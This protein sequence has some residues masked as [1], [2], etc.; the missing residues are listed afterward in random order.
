MAATPISG[1]PLTTKAS[2]GPE[3]MA[4]SIAAGRQRLLHAR[5]AAETDHLDV[6]AVLLEDAGLDADLQRHELERAGLRLADPHLGLR[7]RG[8]ASAV[9]PAGQQGRSVAS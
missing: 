9:R 4:M 5:A 7:L 2:S 8:G 1:A 3:P 6:D